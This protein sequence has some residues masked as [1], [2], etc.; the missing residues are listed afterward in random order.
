MAAIVGLICTTLSIFFAIGA[1]KI[2][3]DSIIRVKSPGTVII[4]LEKA[5]KYTVYY[6]Y[7]SYSGGE[8]YE[9]NGITDGLFTL[10]NMTTKEQIDL[11]SAVGKTGYSMDARTGESI[12]NFEINAP[13]QYVIKTKYVM[14]SGES[15]GL[16]IRPS[17]GS[18][19]ST[20]IMMLLAISLI[21]LAIMIPFSFLL[22]R[23]WNKRKAR[24]NDFN[25]GSQNF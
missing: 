15:Q 11:K 25:T 14:G 10:T 7:D 9:T 4:E 6:E 8:V 5:G 12:A 13:G 19:M 1:T 23:I 18:L 21:C 3:D 24:Q 16:A 2:L 17:F 22:L 20:V